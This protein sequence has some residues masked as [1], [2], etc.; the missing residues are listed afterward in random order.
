MNFENLKKGGKFAVL[1]AY[2]APTAR[3]LEEAGIPLIL[4]GDSL[5]NCV[6]GYK[7]TKSISLEEMLHHTRA[8]AR[9]AT[10][11][12]II[13]DMPINTYTN[14]SLAIINAKK[15]LGAGAHGVKIEGPKIEVVRALREKGIPVMGHIGLTPQTAEQYNVQGKTG[16]DAERLKD[17]ARTLEKAGCFSLV[18]ECIPFSLGKEITELV[19]IPTIGIGAGPFCD[20][21]VLVLSDVLGLTNGKKPKFAKQYADFGN[22]IRKAAENFRNE[23]KDGKFPSEEHSYR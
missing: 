1:T 4:V 23:V 20:G 17:E 14:P 19:G 22:E 3:F 6:L 13:G 7:D 21:Q 15:F 5:A 11:T 8:V 18:L 10:N 12:L 16:E 2:D 9:G